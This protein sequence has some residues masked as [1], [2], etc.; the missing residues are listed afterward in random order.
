MPGLEESL[1][2]IFKELGRMGAKID[3]IRTIRETADRADEKANAALTRSD[4]AEQRAASAHKRLDKVEK[5]INWGVKIVLGAVIAT[6]L[7][8]I[9]LQA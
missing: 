3:D 1:R 2:E 9:G 7:V 5:D 4:A 6:I 8:S